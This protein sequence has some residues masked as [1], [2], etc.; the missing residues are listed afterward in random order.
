MRTGEGGGEACVSGYFRIFLL[1]EVLL[2]NFF[3][4]WIQR[5]YQI[6]KLV[7]ISSNIL[8]P[9]PASPLE[10]LITCLSDHSKLS[11]SSLIL[12]PFNS[13]F[14][15]ISFWVLSISISSSSMFY[16]LLQ[17]PV[18]YEFHLVYFHLRGYSFHLQKFDL[19]HFCVLTCYAFLYLP[20]HMGQ[21]YKNFLTSLSTASLVLTFLL[22]CFFSSLQVVF[23]CFFYA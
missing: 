16:F 10:F 14:L 4:L 17:Y 8:V 6:W 3:N 15:C 18:Y 22:I 1:F 20:E 2:L 23:S 19:G 11:Y 13:F 21:S 5:F 12:C 9:L 7:F